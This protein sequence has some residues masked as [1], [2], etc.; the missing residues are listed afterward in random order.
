MKFNEKLQNL[1]KQKG[2][3]QEELAELLFVTRSAV[4][5]WESGRG[6]PNIDSLKGIS[7]F[8]DVTVDELLS[9]E[10]ILTI[11]QNDNYKKLSQIRDLIIGMLDICNILLLFLPFFAERTN[12]VIKSVP[13]IALTD[14]SIYL[15]IIYYAFVTFSVAFGVAT[16]ALQNFEQSFWH[17]N[18]R[19]ISLI[20]GAIGTIVFTVTLQ[21]YAATFLFVFLMIKFLVPSKKQ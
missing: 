18:K 13:L 19:K 17:K 11:A 21:P 20:M 7:N 4:S 5:K 1:R 14:I 9:G 3:T 10:E 15:K 12:T 2:I 8:F 16:L 6:Y